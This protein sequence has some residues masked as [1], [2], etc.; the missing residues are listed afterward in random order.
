RENFGH[1][2]HDMKFSNRPIPN[3]ELV[4]LMAAQ[5]TTYVMKY[6]V[7]AL[8]CSGVCCPPKPK[9]SIYANTETEK[10]GFKVFT[11]ASQTCCR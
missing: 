9:C 4:H 8:C 7:G 5:S 1:Y 6:S 2:N 11:L 3:M 10:N